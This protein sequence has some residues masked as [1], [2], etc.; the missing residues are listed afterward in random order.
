[1]VLYTINGVLIIPHPMTLYNTL[2]R[3]EGSGIGMMREVEKI[4]STSTQ[5]LKNTKYFTKY[6]VSD[7]WA[8]PL[9]LE[10]GK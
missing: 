3:W 4:R 2:P 10:A 8:N 5:G 6:R 1:M 7:N 9:G